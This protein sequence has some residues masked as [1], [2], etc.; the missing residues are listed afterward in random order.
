MA[1]SAN[2]EIASSSGYRKHVVLVFFSTEYVEAT[3]KAN[4]PQMR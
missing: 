3:A 4:V 1:Q 2:L